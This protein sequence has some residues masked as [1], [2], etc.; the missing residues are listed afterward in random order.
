M[1]APFHFCSQ[2]IEIEKPWWG[3]QGACVISKTFDSRTNI[4]HSKITHLIMDPSGFSFLLYLYPN[5]VINHW[6]N[7]CKMLMASWFG[8][9]KGT[10]FSRTIGLNGEM[11]MDSWFG[12]EKGT[13]NKV[14]ALF[15]NN[16][17][18]D[19]DGGEN[20]WITEIITHFN[21]RALKTKALEMCL[22]LGHNTSVQQQPQTGYSKPRVGKVATCKQCFDQGK[23]YK[24]EA[25]I[26]W[27][28]AVGYSTV[29]SANT[30]IWF[31]IKSLP[32]QILQAN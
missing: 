18:T 31:M 10:N 13:Y 29:S 9:E 12:S 11:L 17:N 4:S 28:D 7:I 15:I 24:L 27:M 6:I 21:P 16:K 19:F 2:N 30:N 23:K 8:S 26:E 22:F 20:F 5:S 14:H 32:K 3:F 25:R 1:P